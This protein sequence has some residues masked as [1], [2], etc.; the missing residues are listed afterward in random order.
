[1]RSQDVLEEYG[2]WEK[3]RPYD[4]VV[5]NRLRVQTPPK[6]VTQKLPVKVYK[7]TEFVGI[8]EK[9]V[10]VPVRPNKCREKWRVVQ[11]LLKKRQGMIR[12][13]LDR[14]RDREGET[15]DLERRLTVAL[16][17][18]SKLQV[19]GDCSKNEA[20]VR[21]LLPASEFGRVEKL[22]R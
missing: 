3:P 19:Y 5:R 1:M 14:E 8:V 6:T 20:E 9:E 15:E 22:W 12:G 13:Q 2:S 17:L 21:M 18:L 10:Q 11:N 16:R 4:G 7:G